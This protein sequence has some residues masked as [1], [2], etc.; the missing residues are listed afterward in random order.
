[1]LANK[2]TKVVT[3]QGMNCSFSFLIRHLLLRIKGGHHKPASY[4]LDGKLLGICFTRVLADHILYF[5]F[6]VE[7]GPKDDF[8]LSEHEELA[9]QSNVLDDIFFLQRRVELH[10]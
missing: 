10:D 6:C 4:G 1:V 9:E 3:E 7:H 8:K 2:V 5:A